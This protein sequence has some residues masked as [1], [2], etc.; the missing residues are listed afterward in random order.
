MSIF[1]KEV[2]SKWDKSIDVN[3]TQFSNIDSIEVTFDIFILLRFTVSNKFRPLNNPF[4]LVKKEEPNPDKSIYLNEVNPLN[5][6]STE[7]I[8]DESN[9]EKSKDTRVFIFS[10]LSKKLF[11][12]STG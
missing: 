2:V 3:K 6:F 5:T 10:S 4:I 8:L 11:K 7:V 9:F 12:L 1:I